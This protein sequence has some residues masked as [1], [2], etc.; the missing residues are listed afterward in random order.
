MQHALPQHPT[1]AKPPT[2][3]THI[4]LLGSGYLSCWTYRYLMR[5]AGRQVRA[6]AMSITCISDTGRHHFHGFTG[7]F[8]SGRLP[9][10][11][12]TNA[13]D[14]LMPEAR[15]I[16]GRVVDVDNASK[17]VRYVGPDGESALLS[18]DEL[19]VG[20]G[21]R[22]ADRDIPGLRT[23]GH[24]L[25]SRE[26][27]AGTRSAI[28]D[29]LRRA[30][31][32]ATNEERQAL[33][34]FAIVGGGVMGAEIAGAVMDALHRSDE[35]CPG[36]AD[37]AE[38]TLYHAGATGDGFVPEYGSGPLGRLLRRKAGRAL[39][40]QG[41][42]IV[43]GARLKE[44]TAEDFL[45]E[46]G[47]RFEA[48]LVIPAIGQQV[49]APAGLQAYAGDSGQ[50]ST[51]RTLQVCGT[52]GIWAGGDVAAVPRPFT[53][54]G[55]C[56]ADALWAIKHGT[57]IGKNLARTHRGRQARQLRFPGLGRA[58][59]FGPGKAILTLYGIPFSGPLAWALRAGFFAYFYPNLP[60][61]PS[62]LADFMRRSGD[63]TSRSRILPLPALFQRT[64]HTPDTAAPR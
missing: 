6:G 54:S 42:R 8:I 12:Y 62:L 20:I 31:M 53:R 43:G 11:H 59:A 35:L 41:I 17:Q 29:V 33:L 64:A 7:E 1:E 18:Y 52:A 26:G 21:T 14:V 30:R 5:M 63:N 55:T 58:A 40:D 23:H 61:V 32:C 60:G 9:L 13:A 48:S 3:S 57:R 49:H 19:V 39:N 45:L 25:K 10:D 51:D 56:P 15:Q 47:R 38:V 44:V 2:A 34:R 22:C 37:L 24:F 28:E 50:L 36:A 27:I 46:D 16:R 4:V